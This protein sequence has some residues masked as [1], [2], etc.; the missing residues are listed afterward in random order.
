MAGN[1]CR[2]NQ[3][4]DFSLQA[5]L[6]LFFA[7]PR[8]W[9]TLTLALEIVPKSLR[10]KVLVSPLTPRRHRHK[11]SRNPAAEIPNFSESKSVRQFVVVPQKVS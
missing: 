5:K 7:V 9:T 4:E 2:K 3:R 11:V 8:T 6:R 1:V 10:G